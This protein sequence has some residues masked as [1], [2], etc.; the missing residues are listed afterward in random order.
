MNRR[1]LIALLCPEVDGSRGAPMGRP[2]HDSY[3]TK[4]GE[5]MRLTVTADGAPFQLT[6]IP[7]SGQGY[8]PGGAY[9]GL[10]RQRLFGFVG[11]ITD[12]RGFVWAAD[13]EA[14]KEAVRA[15]HPKA[16]FFR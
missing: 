12:I 7:I 8:D 4:R 16:R 5:V 6:T 13:R 2:N 3:T 1:D 15:I 11:P 9:W 10:S 14:A